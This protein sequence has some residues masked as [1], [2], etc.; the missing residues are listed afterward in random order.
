MVNIRSSIKKIEN[1][2]IKELKEMQKTAKEVSKFASKLIKINKREASGRANQKDIREKADLT[3]L[4][5]KSIN[6]LVR[7]F[8]G[9]IKQEKREF[10]K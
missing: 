8:N 1:E 2:E 10:R 5:G 4:L 7:L 6:E 9:L 3:N